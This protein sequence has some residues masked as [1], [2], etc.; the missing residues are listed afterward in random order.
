MDGHRSR[1]TT[2]RGVKGEVRMS[3][4]PLSARRRYGGGEHSSRI[5]A[6]GLSRVGEMKVK[7]GI[8][9]EGPVV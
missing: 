5:S 6:T 1:E 9:I 8:R 2:W 3:R 7:L 4:R